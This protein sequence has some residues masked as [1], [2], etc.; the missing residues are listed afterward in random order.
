M[1]RE[2]YFV[3]GLILMALTTYLVRA[4]P[5]V[6]MRKPVKS[7]FLRSFFHYV[8]YSVLAA[9]AFPAVI[10]ATGNTTSG[11]AATLVCILLSFFRLPLPVVAAGGAVTVAAAEI[12]LSLI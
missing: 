10:Y 8:P 2:E 6:L 1:T 11:I 9:M 12:I 3:V 4:V 7:R 5:L